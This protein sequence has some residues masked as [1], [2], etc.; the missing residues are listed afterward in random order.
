MSDISSTLKEKAGPLPVWAWG[1]IL[2][3]IV[4]V[5]LWWYSARGA[6]SAAT[7]DGGGT[8]EAYPDLGEGSVTRASASGSDSGVADS[9]QEFVSNQAWLTFAVARLAAQGYSP[10]EV[11]AALQA[12]LD[13]EPLSKSQ[14][15][16]VNLVVGKYGSPPN[17]T[18]GV[19]TIV[20]DAAKSAASGVQTV[21]TGNSTYATG[22]Q[23]PTGSVS[24]DLISS[25]Q[26]S[27][28]GPT[29]TASKVDG[30]TVRTGA[31]GNVVSSA[32]GVETIIPGSQSVETLLRDMQNAISPATAA[33]YKQALANRG[34]FV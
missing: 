28:V 8:L 30:F 31:N 26:A 1:A 4:I 21:V 11:Q 6:S 18:L 2:G 29:N 10:L 23:S 25:S 27:A 19:S 24:S 33:A 5:G 16:I 12:Y 15:E 22:S 32:N 17:G 3:G 13:G 7:P 20:A 34:V 9:V 14:S